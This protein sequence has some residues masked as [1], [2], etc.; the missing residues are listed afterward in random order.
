MT[1]PEQAKA[2]DERLTAT[3]T[4]SPTPGGVKATP[5]SRPLVWSKFPKRYREQLRQ[6]PADFFPLYEQIEEAKARWH[7]IDPS[8]ST[9]LIEGK[10]YILPITSL[11]T[12]QLLFSSPEE[13]GKQLIWDERL[14]AERLARYEGYFLF[15]MILDS[16]YT[17]WRQGPERVELALYLGGDWLHPLP[18]TPLEYLDTGLAFGFLELWQLLF[19][20]E[21][22]QAGY[23]EAIGAL[24]Y[25]VAHLFPEALARV[26][27]QVRA[28]FA[29]TPPLATPNYRQLFNEACERL[30]AVPGME[31]TAGLPRAGAS[32][33]TVERVGRTL[34]RPLPPELRAFY[35]QVNGCELRW[36]LPATDSAP[37]A[38]GLLQLWTLERVFGGEIWMSLKYWD[39]TINDGVLWGAGHPNYVPGL[40]GLRPFDD[41]EDHGYPSFGFDADPASPAALY[42]I[43]GFDLDYVGRLPL[44][45]AQYLEKALAGGAVRDWQVLFLPEYRDTGED[46]SEGPAI[47]QA[48]ARLGIDPATILA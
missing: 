44:S 18:F 45:F 15:D 17:V 5:A 47:R 40:R 31:L 11:F 36:R 13:Y 35:Q 3:G 42:L 21:A 39:E 24:L 7:I 27:A 22:E 14:P 43:G 12:N 46:P 32:L 1:Y 6:V 16:T 30:R 23:A 33:G 25:Q 48:W 37:A 20:P 34:G 19:I 8:F 2:L 4:Y 9:A 38:E 26:P 28:R 29:P 10:A 41:Q